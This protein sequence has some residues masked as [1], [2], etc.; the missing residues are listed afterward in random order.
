MSAEPNWEEETPNPSKSITAI[1][2]ASITQIA[3][4][5]ATQT[6]TQTP[7]M[8]A[9]PSQHQTP[10]ATPTSNNIYSFYDSVDVSFF[11]EKMTEMLLTTLNIF[12]PESE[13]EM[14]EF[15][16]NGPRLLARMA[17]GLFANGVTFF[18][19]TVGDIEIQI[20][21]LNETASIETEGVAV[22]LP[23]LS[24]PE[25]T[26]FASMTSPAFG[27]LSS[28][29]FSLTIQNQ[30]G[31]EYSVSNMTE[32]FLFNFSGAD[33]GLTNE[34]R[35]E[36]IW[37]NSAN[38]TWL[39]DGCKYINGSC[40]CT[41]LTQFST[42][43]AAIAKINEGIINAIGQLF[44]GELAKK[45]APIAGIIGGVGGTLLAIGLTLI[46]SD[47]RGKRM[48]DNANKGLITILE[49]SDKRA[50]EEYETQ[51]RK[52]YYI[53]M[54][55]IVMPPSSSS[56]SGL[57]NAGKSMAKL[58][59][60]IV[61]TPRPKGLVQT[62]LLW[63]KRMP[64]QH[65]HMALFM[66]YNPRLPRLFR[67]FYLI[68]AFL[69]IVTMSVFFY[70]YRTG[71]EEVMT[72]AENVVLTIMTLCVSIPANKF[73]LWLLNKTGEIEYE[74]LNP[75]VAREDRRRR[76]FANVLGRVRGDVIKDI[77][78]F[79][80]DIKKASGKITSNSGSDV[81][82][83]SVTRNG[84]QTSIEMQVQDVTQ[85]LASV[86]SNG[87]NDSESIFERL[88][89]TAIFEICRRKAAKNENDEY[90]SFRKALAMIKAA[91]IPITS[92]P[93]IHPTGKFGWFPVKSW[94]AVGLGI[95]ELC[96]CFLLCI[97]ILGFAGYK[98]PEDAMNILKTIG[99]SQAT[100]ILLTG[101]IVQLL[102]VLVSFIKKPGVVEKHHQKYL[103]D[104]AA[105]IAV[106]SFGTKDVR[107][108][109]DNLIYEADESKELNKLYK[110]LF[111]MGNNGK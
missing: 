63:L 57:G 87:N 26:T 34:T 58:K 33:A 13:E 1:A 5:S 22:Q 7:L 84:D 65:Y 37:Y 32:P 43:F 102:M 67:A 2:T 49:E 53:D 30:A 15:M 25:G 10:T 82:G 38:E 110:I 64:Y 20:G 28:P 46:W 69:I 71:T 29:V 73:L 51:E 35:V 99:A 88:G 72:T 23:E 27:N 47:K 92:K 96:L 41:H 17:A 50:M 18:S 31:N 91:D 79:F 74:T 44:S 105:K 111:K 75:D 61:S 62:L 8:S 107:V 86:L 77:Q 109:L 89:V 48:W 9:T 19:M 55:S 101:P 80:N 97:Y 42:R 21:V 100:S 6:A 68:P 36:C 108:F 90:M 24:F 11:D 98:S 12:R 93:C 3:T 70:G 4:A 85:I 81:S 60:L 103:N 59:E 14:K 16:A 76:I 66:K 52:R 104:E 106:A 54:L 40:A 83:S 78:L 39:A 45:V 56:P 94:A 95:G